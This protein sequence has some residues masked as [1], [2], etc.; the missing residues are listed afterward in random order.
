M[1][2]TNTQRLKKFL[3]NVE[4]VSE[5]DFDRV[6]KKIEDTGENISE[7]LV[8]EGVIDQEKITKAQAYLAGVPFVDLK[9]RIIPPEVLHLIPEQIARSRRIIP[10][11]QNGN[12]LEVA[13]QD[14]HDLITIEFIKKTNPLLKVLA[15]VVTPEAMRDALRQYEQALDIEFSELLGKPFAEALNVKG[16][17]GSLAKNKDLEKAAHE[18]PVI[19]LV[20]TMLKHAILQRASDVHVEPTEKKLIV[21][22]R[23]DGLLHDALV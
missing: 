7:A 8:A 19:K 20:D 6:A 23:V 18:L 10:F 4:L 5:K 3:T 2:D 1:L 16:L 9:N 17:V 12:V 14:P 21:R 22:F 15:Y 11:R 13:M